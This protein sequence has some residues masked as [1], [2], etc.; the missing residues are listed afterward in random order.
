M[1]K[2]ETVKIIVARVDAY[3]QSEFD[4]VTVDGVHLERGGLGS[5]DTAREIAERIDARNIEERKLGP[6]SLDTI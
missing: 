6:G 2:L 3:G 4:I 1:T 5:Y